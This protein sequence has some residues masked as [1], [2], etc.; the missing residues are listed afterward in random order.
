MK[1][2]DIL[3]SKGD[4][5]VELD[6]FAD[7]AASIGLKVS[8]REKGNNFGLAFAMRNDSFFDMA[9][10]YHPGYDAKNIVIEY[11]LGAGKRYRVN[12]P[13]GRFYSFDKEEVKTL[14]KT[15]QEESDKYEK[16]VAV[17]KAMPK[18]VKAII[19]DLV[20]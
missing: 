18:T 14:H 10:E 17:V 20:K 12:V 2:T 4:D 5:S 1:I 19:K 7:H 11:V 8:K 6:K 16:A 13:L 9:F 15:I 3:E